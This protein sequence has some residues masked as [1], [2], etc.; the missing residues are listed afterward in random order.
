MSKKLILKLSEAKIDGDRRYQLTRI[1]DFKKPKCL[2]VMLN[3]STADD[4]YDDPTVNRLYH[5]SESHGY[6]GFMVVN[7]VPYIS[8]DPKIMLEWVKHTEYHKKSMVYH[9]NLQW[10]STSVSACG[11][12]NVIFAWGNKADNPLIYPVA[13]QI[14]T[15]HGEEARMFG[16]T[17][18]NHPIHPLY[19]LN[20]TRL[21]RFPY[22][23]SS[24]FE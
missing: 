11:R 3:P 8:P 14:I 4:E 18:K 5:F 19:Q 10:V 6:G 1:W 20:E 2:W 7:L 21:A 17:N 15:L 12:K 9:K 23:K 24:W 22:T 16:L 13:Q